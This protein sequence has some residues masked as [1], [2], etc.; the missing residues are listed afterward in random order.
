MR[1][2]IAGM[3][4]RAVSRT[5]SLQSPRVRVSSRFPRDVRRQ[6]A[7]MEFAYLATNS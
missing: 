6:T 7:N 4:E 2:R 3:T 5:M 1:H